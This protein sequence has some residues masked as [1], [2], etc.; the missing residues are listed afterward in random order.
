MV[1]ANVLGNL[2]PIARMHSI[3]F[4]S[5]ITNILLNQGWLAHNMSYITFVDDINYDSFMVKPY[6]NWHVEPY[7]KREELQKNFTTLWSFLL[8]IFSCGLLDL[9]VPLVL[10][11][12]GFKYVQLKGHFGVIGSWAQ[13]RTFVV[14]ITESTTSASTTTT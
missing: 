14:T 12:L 13:A 9:W 3:K 8:A 4:G 6:Y 11:S 5:F 10:N 2:H 7:I 1:L